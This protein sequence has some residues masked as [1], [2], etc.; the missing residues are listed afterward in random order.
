MTFVIDDTE[1][2]GMP[3]VFAGADALIETQHA[4]KENRRL[5]FDAT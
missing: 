5:V 2:V 4:T 3:L 1:L